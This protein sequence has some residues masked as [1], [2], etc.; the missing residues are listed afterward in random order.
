[1]K[2][3]I[4]GGVNQF[5]NLF[6]IAN[7]ILAFDPCG[8]TIKTRQFQEHGSS[9]DQRLGRRGFC[10]E[11][12]GIVLKKIEYL[13]TKGGRTPKMAAIFQWLFLV[14]LIGGR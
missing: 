11:V 1:M 14:P 10:R 6:G 13:P 4:F 2:K 5:G 9:H 7:W 12:K 8:N 3:D